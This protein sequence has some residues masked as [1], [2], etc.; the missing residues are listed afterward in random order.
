MMSFACQSIWR[1]FSRMPHSNARARASRPFASV[2]CGQAGNPERQNVLGIAALNGEV[3]FEAV[4]MA[5]LDD[6]IKVEI[7]RGR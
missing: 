3:V 1:S 4:R 7:F 2:A 5:A 6:F